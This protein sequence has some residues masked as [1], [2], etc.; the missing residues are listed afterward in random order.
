MS[1]I[2]KE[3]F[4]NYEKGMIH[5]AITI[6]DIQN[7]QF[8]KVVRG[9]NPDEVDDFLDELTEQLEAMIKENRELNARIDELNAAAAAAPVQAAPAPAPAPA[10][11]TTPLMDEPQYFKNL[12]T[13]LRETLIN[14]QRLADETV[15]EARKK[16]NTILSNAEEQAAAITASAR[17]E[18]ESARTETDELKAGAAEYRNRFLHLLQEQAHALN[19]DE[20]LFSK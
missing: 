7:K 19:A 10:Q 2:A 16:A 1:N 8:T 13:T 5:M 9:Y 17:A 3:R 12:E 11:T 14:A 20:S 15:S 6:N 4:D 18:V